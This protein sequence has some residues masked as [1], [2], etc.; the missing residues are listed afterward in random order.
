MSA[1]LARRV[2]LLAVA[3]GLSACALPPRAPDAAGQPY[4]N[5][6]L[7]LQV[8]GDKPQ[9]FSAGFELRG[10]PHAGELSLYSPLGATLAQLRWAP[11]MAEL[12]ADGQR[13]QYPS[14]EALTQEATGT[15]LPLPA[16]FAWLD[17]KPAEV[18]GWQADLSRIADGRLVARRSEPLPTAELRIVL[19]QP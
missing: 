9:S 16:L 4:W 7:G 3:L 2:L 18:P 6:R 17:G 19:Q 5:G 8:D 12:Q 13:R 10:A 14:I 1:R 15:A 11:G